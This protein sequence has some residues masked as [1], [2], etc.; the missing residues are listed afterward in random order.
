MSTTS[1][2][3]KRYEVTPREIDD[4]LYSLARGDRGCL[5]D[6]LAGIG[7]LLTG[8]FGIIASTGSG[9]SGYMAIGAVLFVGG[10]A[11]STVHQSRS[12]A[13]RNLALKE[14]PLVIARVLRADAKLSEAGSGYAPAI[15]AFSLEA[16]R[17]FDREQLKV[18]AERLAKAEGE[19]A[20]LLAAPHIEGLPAMPESVTGA[21]AIHVG[22][23][24][25]DREKLSGGTLA[26]G[27]PLVLIVDPRSSFIEHI[28]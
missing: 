21:P 10:F 27:D 9:G 13:L 17:S 16:D 25:V 18:V 23:V 1:A 5:G 15:V 3:R 11:M 4:D 26:A 19:L 8:V 7:A 24:I 6:A 2:L 28:G 20:A 14:G 22:E 12:G